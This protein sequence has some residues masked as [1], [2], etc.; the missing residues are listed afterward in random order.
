MPRNGI[1]R[2]YGSSI[3]SFLRNHHTVFHSGCTN[4]YSHQQCRRVA[5]SPHPL[6]LLLF[7]DLLMGVILIGVTW[8]LIVVLTCIS[9]IISDVEPSLCLLWRNVYL[10]LFPFFN[11]VV[12]FL[13]L[14]CMSCLY[15]WLS[16]CQ[17]HHLQLFSHSVGCLF[18]CFFVFNGLLCCTKA[19]KFD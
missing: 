11:W 8:Y 17:L 10:G 13:R 5:F 12:C 6:W 2:S 15:I 7:V 4:L 14:S 19:Y 3:L 18:V 9:P 16:P 1:T